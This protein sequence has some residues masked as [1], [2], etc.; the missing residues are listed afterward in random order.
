MCTAWIFTCNYKGLG[1]FLEICGLG[2][3]V[4]V[5]CQSDV[6][7]LAEN[8]VCSP[9]FYEFVFQCVSSFKRFLVHGG[10]HFEIM[11]HQDAS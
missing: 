2:D 5:L 3:S 1:Y 4:T 6:K 11:G 10:C 7:Q 8:R 9:Y